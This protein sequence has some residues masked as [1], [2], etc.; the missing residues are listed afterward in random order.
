MSMPRTSL[1][2]NLKNEILAEEEVSENAVIG[3]SIKITS[4]T[5]PPRQQEE[6]DDHKDGSRDDAP[7]SPQDAKNFLSSLRDR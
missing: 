4:P 7:F 3:G 1:Y 2:A 5:P 6:G